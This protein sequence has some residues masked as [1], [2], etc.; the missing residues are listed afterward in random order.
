MIDLLLQCVPPIVAHLVRIPAMKPD[1]L[2]VTHWG[3]AK[4][5]GILIASGAW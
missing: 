3:T 4:F 5:R 1:D 2:G